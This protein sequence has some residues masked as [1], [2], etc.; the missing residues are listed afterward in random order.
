[1]AALYL[2]RHGQASFAAQDYDQL[3]SLGIEQSRVLG[4]HLRGRVLAVDRIVSGSMRR[5]RQTAENSLAALDM[6]SDPIVDPGFNEYDHRDI[7]DGLF[8]PSVLAD[9]LRATA[10]R[11]LGFEDL[12]TQAMARWQGGAHDGDY[13]ETWPA[14]RARCL[15]ALARAQAAADRG[16]T[17]LIFSSGGVISVIVQHLL[18]LPDSEFP[19]LNWLIVN[20]SVTKLVTVGGQLRLSSFNEHAHFE[21]PQK[22]L[23]TYR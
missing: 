19:R 1:M 6:A 2:L 3:S 21:G 23:L 20:A 17:S 4:E 14:F 13:R 18:G 12:F 7:L 16:G 5:H 22:R 11:K 8:E 10:D 9:K 15:E